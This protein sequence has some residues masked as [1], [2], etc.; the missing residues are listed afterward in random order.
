[1][2]KE[3]RKS[4]LKEA[5]KLAKDVYCADEVRSMEKVYH[6]VDRPNE[7][8]VRV[9][10]GIVPDM[11][12]LIKPPCVLEKVLLHV[13]KKDKGFDPEYL[14]TGESFRHFCSEE[15][16]LTGKVVLQQLEKVKRFLGRQPE[17]ALIFVDDEGYYLVKERPTTLREVRALR[18]QLQA[19]QEEEELRMREAAVARGRKKSLQKLLEV[20][21][22]IGIDEAIEKLKEGA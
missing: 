20:A 1:M 7:D 22:K 21:E 13:S 8:V 17:K 14:W 5:Q 6:V 16:I 12:M 11:E 18:N 19:L 3:T 9:L 10:N 4:M 2:P 15:G